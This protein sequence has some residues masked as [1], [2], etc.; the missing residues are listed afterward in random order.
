MFSNENST[1]EISLDF[2]RN[3]S[4]LSPKFIVN[5]IKV[6]FLIYAIKSRKYV[7]ELIIDMNLTCSLIYYRSL[8]L[9]T[10]FFKKQN[11]LH[12]IKSKIVI[13]N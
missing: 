8:I 5:D 7:T 1:S 11:S 9:K 6:S 2:V 12:T 10:F 13:E 4:S 3:K